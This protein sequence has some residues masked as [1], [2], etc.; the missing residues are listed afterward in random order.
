MEQGSVDPLH[1]CEQGPPLVEKLMKGEGEDLI[2]PDHVRGD[3][4]FLDAAF[5]AYIPDKNIF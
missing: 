5:H 3:I 1:A 2:T 4:F